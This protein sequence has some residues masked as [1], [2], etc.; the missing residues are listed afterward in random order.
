MTCV[1]AASTGVG[2][3]GWTLLTIIGGRVAAVEFGS[4]PVRV[5]K[6]LLAWKRASSFDLDELEPSTT[7]PLVPNNAPRIDEGD[8]VAAA[9]VGGVSK[10]DRGPFCSDAI[11]LV[12]EDKGV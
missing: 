11:S 4:P 10:I 8:N 9:E 2:K 6:L 5:I 12:N 1:S 3:V 7:S